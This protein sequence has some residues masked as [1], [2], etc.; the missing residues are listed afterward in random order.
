MKKSNSEYIMVFACYN[1]A[2]FLY[3]KLVKNGYKVK[4]V[5]TPCKISSG[6]SHSIRFNEENFEIVK[7]EAEKNNI[8]PKAVY[9]IVLQDGKENYKL[10]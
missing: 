3:N 5:A 2:V 4:L 7:N 6:C 10:L 1:K 9:K 8:K